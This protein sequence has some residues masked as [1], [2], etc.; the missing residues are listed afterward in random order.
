MANTRITNYRVDGT[1]A[2]KVQ[3]PPIEKH[4]ATIVPFPLHKQVSNKGFWGIS[5]AQLGNMLADKLSSALEESEMYCSLKYE[6][7][8][9]CAYRLF[10]RKGLAVLSAM[11]SAIAVA[12]IAIGS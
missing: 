8:H 10:S 11:T 3:E 7:F 4:C 2:L 6:D 9:G 5:I 12:A 1:A